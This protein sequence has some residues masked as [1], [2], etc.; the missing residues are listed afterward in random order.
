MFCNCLFHIYGICICSYQLRIVLLCGGLVYGT[1][2]GIWCIYHQLAFLVELL[3]GI[4]M[5]NP[6]AVLAFIPLT[7]VPG[8]TR[9]Q[10]LEFFR[11]KL[12]REK[13]FQTIAPNFLSKKLY[14]Y[15]DVR[16]A[17]S[18]VFCLR[19]TDNNKLPPSY[20]HKQMKMG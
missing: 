20:Q 9:L 5:T 18:F 13:L 3:R 8:P 16:V 4:G 12:L 19:D 6:S 2:F 17:H 1:S 7:K 10:C 11:S 15:F 14:K